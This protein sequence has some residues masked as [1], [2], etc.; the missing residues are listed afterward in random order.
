MG[1][2]DA[3]HR[4]GEVSVFVWAQSGTPVFSVLHHV[5]GSC[6]ETPV[7]GNCHPVVLLNSSQ[8]PEKHS[9]S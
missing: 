3:F 2:W 4:A 1:I 5:F 7:S 6:S 8:C 9:M